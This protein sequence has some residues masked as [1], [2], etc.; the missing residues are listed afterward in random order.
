MKT[1]IEIN[2][3]RLYQQL[4]YLKPIW[5]FRDVS[6]NKINEIKGKWKQALANQNIT[7]NPYLWHYHDKKNRIELEDKEGNVLH[8]YQ[9]VLSEFNKMKGLE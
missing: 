9:N 8:I 4:K 6:K 3:T 5:Y 1:I 2:D 7:F